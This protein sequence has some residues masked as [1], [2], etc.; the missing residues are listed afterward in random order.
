MFTV[1]LDVLDELVNDLNIL[2]IKL[3]GRE[4]ANDLR[5]PDFF[6]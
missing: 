5:H 6:I 2:V 1:S 4:D 3:V